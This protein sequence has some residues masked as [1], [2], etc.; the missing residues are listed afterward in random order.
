MEDFQK[1]PWGEICWYF[2]ETKEQFRLN[3][4]ME[5]LDESS[6]GKD[7]QVKHQ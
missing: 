7:Q 4:K 6:S 3:G 5:L 1:Q 2:T